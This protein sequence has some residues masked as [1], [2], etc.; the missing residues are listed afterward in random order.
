MEQLSYEFSEIGRVPSAASLIV[1]A[2]CGVPSR[3]TS[4]FSIMRIRRPPGV[5]ATDGVPAEAFV[6]HSSMHF[7][8]RFWIQEKNCSSKHAMVAGRNEGV[9]EGCA[10]IVVSRFM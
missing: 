7:V 4:A 2:R 3:G 8:H 9:F 5:M 1:V 6:L 10:D